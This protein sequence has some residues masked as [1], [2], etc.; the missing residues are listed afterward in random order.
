MKGKVCLVTGAN[1]GIGKQTA[2]ELARMGANVV[3]VC[4]NEERG[5]R[6]MSEIMRKTSSNS[7]D[8][9]IADLSS[10]NQIRRLAHKF[11]D[12]YQRL[13]VLINNAGIAVDK[14]EENSNGIEMILAVNYLAPFL[15]TH[16]LLDTL[17]ISAPSRLINVSSFVHRWTKGINFDDLQAEE[18]F[19][20]IQVYAQSKL[21]ILMFT[22]ELARRLEGTGITVNALNPGLVKTNLG[23]DLTGV[24]KVLEKVLKSTLGITSEKGARTSI[25][26]ASSPEVEGIT[27]Q[28]FFKQ[29]SKRSSRASYDQEA[30][31]RLWEISE[32]LTGLSK[33]QRLKRAVLRDASVQLSER[34]GV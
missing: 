3:M 15:L 10:Q 33:E 8:L 34:S 1:S 26:L 7:V 12:R 29:K 18:K 28:Y 21:A 16:L 4:R 20:A 31:L 30:W 19:S 6:A 14:R 23:H 32:E 27:G 22:Y 24:F 5:A 2:M 11:Q 9:M 13:D 17:K 25:Y